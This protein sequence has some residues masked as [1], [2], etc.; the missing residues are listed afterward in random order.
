M[1]IATAGYR[2][3]TAVDAFYEPSSGQRQDVVPRGS[4]QPG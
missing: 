1:I 3:V 2:V 4:G